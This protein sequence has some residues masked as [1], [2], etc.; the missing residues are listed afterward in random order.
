MSPGSPKGEAFELVA[1]YGSGDDTPRLIAGPDACPK[2]LVAI[3][4][5]VRNDV[6][7]PASKKE[8]LAYKRCVSTQKGD[9]LWCHTHL[10]LMGNCA[11]FLGDDRRAPGGS[12]PIGTERRR[13]ALPPPFPPR[14]REE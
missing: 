1:E 11:I 10:Y 14:V 5:R 4:V 8:A 2:C 6:P 13:A 9:W 3:L 7:S 12:R